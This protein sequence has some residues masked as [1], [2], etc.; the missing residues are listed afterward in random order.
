MEKRL[1]QFLF[2][3]AFAL[4]SFGCKSEFEKIRASGDTDRIYTKAFEYYEQEEYLRAQTLLELIIPAYR[5]KPELEKIYFAYA[6][7]WESTSWVTI[8]S[9]I[10]PL[11]FPTALSERK[12]TSW[13][14]TP[15][16]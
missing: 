15:T 12:Q 6:D 8:I 5:G 10:L 1:V 16:T 11:P 4:L 13:W 7:T 14:L 2:L 3:S 9:R